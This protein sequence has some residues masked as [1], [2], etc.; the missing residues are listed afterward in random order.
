MTAPTAPERGAAMGAEL[1]TSAVIVQAAEAEAIARRVYGFDGRAEWLWGEKDSNY[2]LTLQQG[3]EY[4]L[5]ILSPAED[6]AVSA[7]HSAALQHVEQVDGGI[8]VQRVIATLEGEANHLITDK[9]GQQRSVRLV[10]FLPGIAQRRALPSAAQRYNVG[11][12][13]ARLQNALQS[14]HHPAAHHRITWDMSHASA[15][16]ELLPSFGDTACR[17]TLEHALK[18][19]EKQV[20]PVMAELPMQVIHNDFNIENILTDADQPEQISGII[21]FGD[22]VHAPVLFDVAIAASYQIGP[23]EDAL[24]DICDFLA[25]YAT[26]RSLS[27][28]EINLLYPAIVM[29]MVMRLTITQWR[30]TLFP[31]QHA[32]LTRHNR[33]VESQLAQLE[34][35]APQEVLA[36]FTAACRGN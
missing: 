30:A 35:I 6:P 13:L 27:A 17:H 9:S 23:G 24:S 29:R 21:D 32:R 2:R 3:R 36:R 11:V 7:M 20:L 15:M 5:K 19:F 18:R 28:T 1:T 10:T 25:G 26:L 8:P 4:L 16:R 12:M 33:L 31:E 34:A 14:F 22:M